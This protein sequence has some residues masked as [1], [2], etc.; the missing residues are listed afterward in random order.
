MVPSPPGNLFMN[1]FNENDIIE[2]QLTID[3]ED[4]NKARLCLRGNHTSST[5]PTT[6]IFLM[7][8]ILT[9]TEHISYNEIRSPIQRF[10]ALA[11]FFRRAYP[12]VWE[13]LLNAWECVERAKYDEIAD[14]VREWKLYASQ[15]VVVLEERLRETSL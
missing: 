13:K 8:A 14:T 15:L 11:I 12:G 9:I 2:L 7:H 10:M 3:G 1:N 6:E 5:T 4:V